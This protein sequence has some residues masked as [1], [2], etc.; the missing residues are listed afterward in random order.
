[1]SAYAMLSRS[2][3]E[4]QSCAVMESIRLVSLASLLRKGQ[5]IVPNGAL[6]PGPENGT[7]TWPHPTLLTHVRLLRLEQH[8]EACAGARSLPDGHQREHA[9]IEW[10]ALHKSGR[11]FGVLC[12]SAQL[13]GLR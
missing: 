4:S 10:L 8:A 3:E 13:L 11:T 5:N 9:P 6:E 2:W 7:G 12:K 1:M